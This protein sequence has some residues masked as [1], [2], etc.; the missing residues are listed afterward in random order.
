MTIDNIIATITLAGSDLPAYKALF[1][2]IIST[3]S[4]DDQAALQATYTNSMVAAASAH[5]A[6]QEG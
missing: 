2:E 6:A 4:S 3:M 5:A 1:D